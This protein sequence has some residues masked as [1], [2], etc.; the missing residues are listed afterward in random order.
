MQPDYSH[1]SLASNTSPPRTR[2]LSPV[3]INPTYH[4]SAAFQP[5]YPETFSL[6]NSSRLNA[7][8]PHQFPSSPISAAYIPPEFD[9]SFFDSLA[10]EEDTFSAAVMLVAMSKAGLVWDR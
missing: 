6:S 2:A 5:H 9:N 10:A 4:D 3:Q 8:F 7:L 1:N